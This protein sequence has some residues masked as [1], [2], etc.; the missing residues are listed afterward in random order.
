MTCWAPLENRRFKELPHSQPLKET[1]TYTTM[2][3]CVRCCN[4]GGV[5]RSGAGEHGILPILEGMRSHYVRVSQG[6]DFELGLAE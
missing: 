5:Y 1:Y 6:G 3:P 4:A 2:V